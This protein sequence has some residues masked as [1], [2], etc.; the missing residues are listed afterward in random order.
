MRELD[1]LG[2]EVRDQLGE[3]SPDWLRRQQ[4]ALRAA[5]GVQTP[6]RA[7][8]GWPLASVLCA[9]MLV[10]AVWVLMARRTAPSGPA[11]LALTASTTSRRVPLADGS[12]LA[13]SAHTQAHLT[14]TEGATSCVIDVG[15]VAFDVAPQHGRQFI[16]KAGMFEVTVVGTRF[17]V[18]RD[19]AGVVEIVVSH[20]VVRVKV[21]SRSTPTELRAGD[22]LRSDGAEA[23][24]RHQ[25]PSPAAKEQGAVPSGSAEAA[26]SLPAALDAQPAVEAPSKGAAAPRDTWL[27]LYRERNY[28][29]A[30]AAA[31]EVGVD[32][33]LASLAAQPLSELADAA[34]LGGD[35]D[36]ALRAFDTLGRRFPASRQAQDALFLSGRMLATRGQAGVARRQF[37][38]YLARNGQG[39]YS[40]EA[41]GRLVEI[42][43]S[44]K[45]PRAA[46]MAR[47]YL[48]R[49]PQ[50]PYRRLCLSVLA[51]P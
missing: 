27:R 22:Q 20:G 39:A 38:A 44:S 42:Y 15:K 2:Q 23:L 4:S 6:K 41:L 26:E 34:R 37:E 8:G 11:E 13:L 35:G 36:L 25:S 31:R 30:L 29:A 46:S 32:A 16:V 10:T 1:R 33:L 12:S 47:A 43:A 45:D 50:G 14:V 3:P 9:V 24:L 19:Q 40:V 51:A 5:L 7:V 28:A 48:E 18:S 21:P 17:S 49:A